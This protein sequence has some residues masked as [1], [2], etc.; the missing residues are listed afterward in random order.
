MNFR[1]TAPL[2]SIALL[3]TGCAVGNRFDYANTP[4]KAPAGKG[5]VAIA[6]LDVRPDLL[7]GDIT[8]NYVGMIHG[9]FGVPYWVRTQ[10][11]APLA[12]EVAQSV[13]KGLQKAG[14]RTTVLTDSATSNQ[15]T[16]IRALTRT[17]SH[18]LVLVKLH[19]WESS[20]YVRTTLV[21]DVTVKVL[22]ASGDKI[23]SANLSGAREL[24]GNLW[25]PVKKARHE[26]LSS[27]S[28][29]V[30]ELLARP[31]IKDALR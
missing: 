16:A 30:D 4:V 18:R 8:P 23:V 24:H 22:D 15:A 1:H 26:V 11:D 2:L 6:G 12:S 14:Y 9:R 17:G 28:Q 27:Y 21:Y 13:A 19:Q 29:I 31:E 5:S 10:S 25:D 7:V 3:F 20:T